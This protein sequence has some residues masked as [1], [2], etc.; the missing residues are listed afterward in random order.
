MQTL[1]LFIPHLPVQWERRKHPELARAALIVGGF[2]YER[3]AV[4]DCSEEAAVQGVSPGMPLRQA[5][6]R[7]P[8][9]VFL[10]A[11]EA[12]CAG[13]SGEVLGLLDRFS[14]AVEPDGPGRAFIDISGTEQLFGPAGDLAGQVSRL[15][16]RQAG[17]QS[18]IGVAGSKFV[19]GIAASLASAGPL[20][21]EGGRERPFLAPLSIEF[22]PLA[23]EATAWLKRLGLRTMGQV[24][25]LPLNALDSQLGRDGLMAHRLANGIDQRP[26]TPGPGP[27][28]LAE[29]LSFEQPL[30]SL[31]ALLTALG[32]LLGRLTPRLRS[33]YQV[34]HQIRLCLRSG[35][36]RAWPHT[37]NLKTPSDSRPGMLGILKRHLEAASFPEGVSEIHLVL[38]GLHGESGRQ[39]P[40]STGTK[41]LQ[42]EA[43]QRLNSGL[44]ER[45]GRNPLKRVVE[46]DSGSRI[47]ERRVAL[48]DPDAGG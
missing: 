3:T 42:A 23:P 16:L 2:P 17:F 35:D 43:L 19:A 15:I 25:G 33:R 22:L 27:D 6:H 47:P 32:R 31:E 29:T 34:C 36:G 38:A 24:A 14:P 41:G 20:I 21:V 39:A 4:L 18:R 8:G 28:T 45:F 10:P 40:L 5:S 44:R 37:L 12:G 7:C 9:A 46:I 13:A 11:D 1:C 30:G 26:V 48:V